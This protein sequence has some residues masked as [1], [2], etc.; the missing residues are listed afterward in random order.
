M[1]AYI[2]VRHPQCS[3][4]RDCDQDDSAA[5]ESQNSG[6][7]YFWLKGMGDAIFRY[8]KGERGAIGF[9]VCAVA[10]T[11]SFGL[12]KLIGDELL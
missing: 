2:T 4:R 1:L 5:Q 11:R 8:L 9:P 6:C 3:R 7:D 10:K 12:A